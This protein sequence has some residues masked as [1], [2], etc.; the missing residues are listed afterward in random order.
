[1]STSGV[2]V[3]IPS[4]NNA[5]F[6]AETLESVF[7]QTF[8]DYEV[9]VVND[10]SPDTPQLERALGPYLNRIVYFEQEN[11]G[12]AGARN[13]GIRQARGAFL[14]FLDSDDMWLPNFLAEQMK[15]FETD[16]SLDLVYADTFRF[17]EAPL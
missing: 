2:S 10:G 4:Y 13:A 9:I 3:I 6:I 16:P 15:F 7:A 14:A 12:P 8:K 11:K 1:M 17:R 5:A